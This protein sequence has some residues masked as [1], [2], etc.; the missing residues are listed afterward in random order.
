MRL[1]YHSGY[2]LTGFAEQVIQ[3]STTA[4]VLDSTGLEVDDEVVISQQRYYSTSRRDDVQLAQSLTRTI[5]AIDRDSHT[6]TFN[7]RLLES[8]KTIRNWYKQEYSPNSIQVGTFVYKSAMFGADSVLDLPDARSYMHFH[9][10]SGINTRQFTNDQPPETS[11][12]INTFSVLVRDEEGTVFV[13]C[14]QG[15]NFG[16]QMGLD[17]NGLITIGSAYNPNSNSAKD[18]YKIRYNPE[19]QQISFEAYDSTPPT[20]DYYPTIHQMFIVGQ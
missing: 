18:F 4:V 1:L 10:Q 19:T 13:D 8:G 5:T 9:F 11:G 6:L 15:Y 7:D 2:V 16:I 3:T 17:E 12:N 14:I 20:D